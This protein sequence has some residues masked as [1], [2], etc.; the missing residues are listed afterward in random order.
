MKKNIKESLFIIGLLCFVLGSAGV[1]FVQNIGIIDFSDDKLPV[2]PY[3]AVTCTIIV[4]LIGA[5]IFN[6]RNKSDR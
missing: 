2:N 3:M 6:K 5:I 4:L 1:I